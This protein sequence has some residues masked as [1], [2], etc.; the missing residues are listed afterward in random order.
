MWKRYSVKVLQ[1][2][3]FHLEDYIAAIVARLQSL[4]DQAPV[5]SSSKAAS[6]SRNQVFFSYSH[7]DKEWLEKIKKALRPFIRAEQL[8]EWDDS[9]IEA[10]DQWRQEIKNALAS[11]K[12]AV[13]LVSQAFFDSEFISSDE[14]PDLLEAAENKQLTLIPVNLEPCNYD[15]SLLKEHQTIPEL[16]RPLIGLAEAE[17]KEALA[18]IARTIKESFDH[19]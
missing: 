9:Q 11:A 1:R 13:L 17:C 15:L 12:V 14:L 7:D 3:D 16:S 18:K 2:P 10:G 4:P 5:I 19:V 8:S 6:S